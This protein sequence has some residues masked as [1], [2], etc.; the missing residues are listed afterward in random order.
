MDY[1]SDPW[2]YADMVYIYGSITNIFLQ[3]TLGPFHIASRIIMCIIIIL[4]IVKTFF[5]MRIFPSLTPL[6]VMLTSVFAD[7]KAFMT[8]YTILIIMLGQ[9]Y[10]IIGLANAM[11]KGKFK[12]LYGSYF[13]DAEK[14]GDVS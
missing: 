10:A 7:L 1:L 14:T 13:E 11:K 2:N 12:T 8:F 3:L 6:V 9:L 5:F 4:L